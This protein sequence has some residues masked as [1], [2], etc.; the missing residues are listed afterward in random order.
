MLS[1]K[2]L[3][4]IILVFAVTALFCFL[5]GAAFAGG[6]EE[7]GHSL[8]QSIGI[9]IIAATVLAFT[10]HFLK[11]PLLLSYIAAGVIIGPI[12]LHLISSKED[13][14]TI[15]EIGLILLLFMI[16]LEIDM[17][18]LKES[19]KAL[20]MSGV[21][22]FVLCVALGLAF[23]PLLGFSI[24]GGKYDL[25]YLAACCALSSTAI[26]VKLLYAKFELDTL[27]G[28]ITLGVLVFQDIWAIVILGV[29]PNL[30]NPDILTILMSFGKGGLLV[31]IALLISKYILPKLFKSIAKI[32]ELVLVASLGW[33]FLICSLAGF[34]GL[35]IEMGALIAG[36]A[37]STFPYNLDVIAKVISIR[38]FFV[39]LFFVALGMK[40]PN[41]MDDLGILAIAAV[42]AV[43]LIIS[44]FLSVYPIL[45]LLKQGNR[46]SL[47]PSINLANLSEFSLVIASL[48]YSA[49]HI[50]NKIL[51]I[52]IFVF[53]ITS[54]GAPYLIKYS[55]HIQTALGKFLP[56]I[57]LKDVQ[58]VIEKKE[59]EEEKDIALLGFFRVASSLIKEIQDDKN[60]NNDKAEHEDLFDKIVV[61]DFNPN[62]H[63]KLQAL[64]VKAMYGDISNMD[65]L[66]HAGIHGAKLVISTIPDTVLVGTDNLKMIRQIQSLCP[67]AKI[68]VTAESAQRAQKMYAEGADYVFL[69]RVL[70]ADHLKQVIGEAL[71]GDLEKIKKAHIE[72]LK[73]VDEIIN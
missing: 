9:S 46:I 55:L 16:G 7:G 67:H 6:G 65:T 44:R 57:G 71:N 4:I 69:P 15:S 11:Q 23:F 60:A 73:T 26:V 64:G 35:S 29:Q 37:I 24:G 27:A 21:F 41:P 18:K 17:K 3:R 1:S 19:G 42:T 32:P 45:Y 70:A 38:D 31:G 12:G 33:C 14:E 58:T 10:F 43:F 20:I 49:G 62:V 47:L 56:K 30:A 53:V 25:L 36:V 13:I 5:P 54:I 68:I 50:D 34:L 52:I 2:T 28:R 72:K 63:A 66:H 48:G 61:V 51:S 22:Q 40:I 39:T 59:E 8:I